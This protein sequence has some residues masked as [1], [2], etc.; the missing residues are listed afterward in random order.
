MAKRSFSED[1][2]PLFRGYDVESMKPNGID[3][4]SYAEVKSRAGD[5]YSK[6]QAKDMPCDGGWSDAKLLIFKEWM[7]GGMAP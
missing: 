2:R 6:L 5:I 3:L 7:E 1:I 4:S